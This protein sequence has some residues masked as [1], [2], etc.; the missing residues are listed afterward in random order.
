VQFKTCPLRSGWI[1]AGIAEDEIALFCELAARGDYG[2]L[3]AAG[4][5]IEI[6][7]WT[8]GAEGCCQ[9]KIRP[10]RPGVGRS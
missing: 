7:T 9:L 5:S 3:E 6:K 2:T 1:E 8:P 4:F 10:L